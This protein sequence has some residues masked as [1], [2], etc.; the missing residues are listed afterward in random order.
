[1]SASVKCKRLEQPVKSIF[2]QQD[3]IEI[4]LYFLVL[5]IFFKFRSLTDLHLIEWDISDK[6]TLEGSESL[7]LRLLDLT[8]G[9]FF[10]TVYQALNQL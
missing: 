3:C 7:F 4:Q 5:D 9:L 2:T 8:K 1:M 10:F 6:A